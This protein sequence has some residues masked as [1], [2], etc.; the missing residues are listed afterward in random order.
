MEAAGQLDEALHLIEQA[1][2]IDP[3]AE[4]RYLIA[5]RILAAQGRQGTASK[6]L[7]RGSAAIRHAGC[8]FPRPSRSSRRRSGSSPSTS[9]RR[10]TRVRHPRDL[11]RRLW[12]SVAWSQPGGIS[13]V[14]DQGNAAIAVAVIAV[15][16]LLPRAADAQGPTCTITWDGQAGNRWFDINT[17]GNGDPADDIYSWSPERYPTSTDH[18]CFPSGSNANTNQVTTNTP[19]VSS[20]AISAGASLTVTDVQVIARENSTNAGTLNMAAPLLNPANRACR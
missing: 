19:D 16:A 3:L 9:G 10:E 13:D 17:Q 11:V 5:A 7:A 18:A 4:R 6:M 15:L 8:P 1:I 14:D 20:F 12:P 2:E